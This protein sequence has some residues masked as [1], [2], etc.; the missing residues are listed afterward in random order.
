MLLRRSSLR[1]SYKA[2]VSK[3]RSLKTGLII[4]FDLPAGF[5]VNYALEFIGNAFPS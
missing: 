2:G 3:Y 4:G 5:E 1:H